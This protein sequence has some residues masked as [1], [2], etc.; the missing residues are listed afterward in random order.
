MKFL[1][2]V[3]ELNLVVVDISAIYIF[4]SPKNW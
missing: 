1:L 2:C 3:S 4:Y